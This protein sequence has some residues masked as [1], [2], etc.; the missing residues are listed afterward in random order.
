MAN[1]YN[2]K[3]LTPAEKADKEIIDL[4][5]KR[6]QECDPIC[7]EIYRKAVEDIKFSIGEQWDEQAKRG[8]Q[9]RPCLVENRILNTIHQVCNNQRQNRP[10][11]K[12]SPKR[13]TDE[14]TAE[15]Y[16]GL[17]RHIQSESD[18]ESA[19]DTAFEDAVRGSVGGFRIIT[20]YET[21]DSFNQEI[22]I[23]RIADFQSMKIPYHLCVES[24]FRDMPYA[25]VET[26][27]QKD[28]FEKKW[29]DIDID[30]WPSTAR[31]EGWQNE[32][33]IRVAEYYTIDET[34]HNLYLH[35]DGSITEEKHVDEDT[36]EWGEVATEDGSNKSPIVQTRKACDRVIKWYKITAGEILD[37]AIIPGMWIPVVIVAGEDITI[38]GK[39]ELLSLT[40]N[41]K[42]PQRMLNYWR[43]SEA[44]RIALAPKAPWVAVEG[45][46]EGREQ[47]W[48]DSNRSNIP[49]LTYKTVI[50]GGVMAPAPARAQPAQM[51]TAI[52]N[53]AREA[54]DSI[55]ACTGIFDASLGAT[56][57]EKSGVA[58]RARQAQG[59]SSNYHFFDNFA[60]ALRHACRIIVDMIPAVYDTERKIKILGEDMKEKIITV[61]G[62]SEDGE[63]Q[64]NLTVGKYDV[65]VETGPSFMSRRQETANNLQQLAQ[66][67]PVIIQCARDLVLKYLDLPTEVV[68][69]AQKTIDPKFLDSGKPGD[70]KVIQGQLAQAT[71]QVQQLD[72][73]I[74]QMSAENDDMKQQLNV[75]SEDNKTR[76][77]IAGLQAQVN[78]LLGQMK[79]GQVDKQLLH[80]A[81]LESMRYG[82]SLE[83]GEIEAQRQ[84]QLKSQQPP[85]PGAQPE[86]E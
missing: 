55:K 84:A 11:I 5:L 57:N 35:E 72:Q 7:Q 60:R 31:L 1:I 59:D 85:Q 29:P 62:Q 81:A 15:V 66:S 83:Q 12:V 30:S 8:R 51:D 3:R 64:Y 48:A 40:R 26:T 56:S 78:L 77:A 73:V 80:E 2:K 71:Q 63:E 45:Q 67:D 53:A 82:N 46:L 17:L 39:R 69:R 75:K 34:Y 32:E 43:S 68:E 16:N 10:M 24:D 42:D 65:Q 76:L 52:V 20:E 21:D 74:Q 9:D 36:E 44:E 49:V 22:R 33:T 58:I 13:D 23:K 61:N 6:Y 38:S 25:F 47:L 18:A 70:P 14:T 4:A 79:S 86:M 54:I 37:R 19:F 28:D 41:A 50:E 27:Y